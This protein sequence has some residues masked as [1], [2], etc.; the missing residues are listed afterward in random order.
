MQGKCVTIIACLFHYSSLTYLCCQVLGVS[1]KRNN[2][3]NISKRNIFNTVSAML[4]LFLV[5][6]IP[7]GWLCKLSPMKSPLC[8]VPALLKVMDVM[9]RA[10]SSFLP[11]LRRV[12]SSFKALA[13]GSCYSMTLNGTFSWRSFYPRTIVFWVFKRNGEQ[14][15]ETT[16]TWKLKCYVGLLYCVVGHSYFY[17]TFRDI[18]KNQH[19]NF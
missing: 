19:C 15:V 3:N 8:Y 13:L 1:G 7:P 5:I 4:F 6:S 11:G 17:H 18:R 16:V 14:L 12:Q 10:A 2:C 9:R